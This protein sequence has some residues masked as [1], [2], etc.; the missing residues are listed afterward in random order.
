MRI[1]GVNKIAEQTIAQMEELN[2]EL[3]L[4]DLVNFIV[5]HC[6]QLEQEQNVEAVKHLLCILMVRQKKEKIAEIIHQMLDVFLIKYA[7]QMV[8][9]K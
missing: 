2:A 9:V 4:K 5:I 8:S 6:H 1:H 3:D 7:M